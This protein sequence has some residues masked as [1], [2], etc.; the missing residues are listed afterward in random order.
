MLYVT[1]NKITL[2]IS[3]ILFIT[4]SLFADT[5]VLKD[6]RVVQGIFKG[7]TQDVVIF[8]V[9]GNIQ[10]VNVTDIVSLTFSRPDAAPATTQTP[11]P[12]PE[13]VAVPA[14]VAV[15]VTSHDDNIVPKDTKLIVELDKEVS[16]SS[17]EKGAMVTGILDL[18]LILNGKVI[19]PKGSAVYGTVVES[20]GGRRIG[21]KS[22]VLTFV[23]IVVNGQKVAIKTGQFG[24]EMGPD[25]SVVKTAAAGAAIGAAFGGGSG[26][27]KGAA[28]GA[29]L[30]LLTGS[31]HIGIPAGAMVEVTLLEDV[32]LK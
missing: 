15:G 11:E 21:T 5:I 26:A 19:S 25:G 13:A 28:V 16:T 1:R 2:V 17:H 12:T 24:A 4:V 9:N 7:G 32:K 3:I 18:D 8:D 14:A 20:E 30:S 29:G 6:G 22:L 27:G 10:N 23:G 31:R